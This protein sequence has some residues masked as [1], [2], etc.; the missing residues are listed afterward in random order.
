MGQLWTP[1]TG[2]AQLKHRARERTMRLPNGKLAK[3][4]I[5]DSSTVIHIEDDEHQDAIVR[6]DVIRIKVQRFWGPHGHP[7][8]EGPLKGKDGTYGAGR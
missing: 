3:V 5:D 7:Q 8:R 1:A 4:S 6:P 2:V